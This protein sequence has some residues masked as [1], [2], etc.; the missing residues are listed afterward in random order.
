[1]YRHTCLN[2]IDCGYIMAARDYNNLFD[3]NPRA[4]NDHGT[5]ACLLPKLDEQ[6]R[7]FQDTSKVY[8]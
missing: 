1:M 2:Y 5:F 6:S 3:Y 7:D 4:S 8:A